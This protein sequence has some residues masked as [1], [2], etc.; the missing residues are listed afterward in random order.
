MAVL[1]KGGSVPFVIERRD[2][3]FHPSVTCDQCDGP[4]G[5]DGFVLWNADAPP[6]DLPHIPVLIAC[7]EACMEVLAT[8]YADEAELAATP[9]DAYL[10]NLV[11]NLDIDVNRVLKR[12]LAAWQA[13][14][15]RDEAPE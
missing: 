5:P 9:L 1:G 14:R 15:T 8:Q 3:G 4:V 13:E 2:D 6:Q 11:F 12:E 10:A 7:S